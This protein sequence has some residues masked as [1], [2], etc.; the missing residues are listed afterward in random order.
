MAPFSS[1]PLHLHTRY[2][3]RFF[4]VCGSMTIWAG[5]A[6]VELGPGDFYAVARGTP[7]VI[8]AG[9]DGARSLNISSPAAFADLVARSGSDADEPLTDADSTMRFA[10]LSAA[11]GD[12]ILGPPGTRP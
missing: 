2:D 1:T 10:Q 7:H 4:V 6:R 9:A 5:A 8:E 12:V 3:E 11:L